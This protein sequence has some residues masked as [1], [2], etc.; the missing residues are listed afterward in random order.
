MEITEKTYVTGDDVLWTDHNGHVH[1]YR[2]ARC[3]PDG[4]L[5]LTA[6]GRDDIEAQPGTLR[7]PS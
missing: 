3:N 2:V 6:P 5:H 1:L 7:R 4:S